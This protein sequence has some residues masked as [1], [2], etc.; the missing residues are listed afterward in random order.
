MESIQF[1][2]DLNVADDEEFMEQ[3]SPEN[4]IFLIARCVAVIVAVASMMILFITFGLLRL[5]VSMV[6]KRIG[7]IGFVCVV[8]VTTVSFL[9]VMKLPNTAHRMIG[10]VLTRCCN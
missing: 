10:V 4:M 6:L 1:S 5:M 3:M 7:L 8:I 9:K 2:A